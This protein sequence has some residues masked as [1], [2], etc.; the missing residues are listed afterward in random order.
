MCQHQWLITNNIKN[1]LFTELSPVSPVQQQASYDHQLLTLGS[2]CYSLKFPHRWTL[3]SDETQT[4]NDHK[5]YHIII[6]SILSKN[7]LLADQHFNRV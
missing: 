6:K 4:V 5:R 2:E 3:H 1:N 7:N